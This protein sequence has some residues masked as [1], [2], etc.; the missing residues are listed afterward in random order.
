M[1]LSSYFLPTLREAPQDADN[2]SVK[3]MFRAG[4]IRKLASGIY[5]WLPLGLRVLRKVENIVREELDAIGGQ[6]VWLPVIQP[7]ELWM[8]TGRWQIYGKELLRIKDRKD[9]Q[10][11][12]AP[13]AEEVITNMVRRDVNSY[14]Q[15][16]IMLYQ[17]GLK[18]RDE[19][20]PRF[21]VM[22]AREFLM[23]D[24]YSFHASDEDC[25]KWY[26]RVYG[27]YERIFRR[28]GLS[29]KSV[30][31]DSGPIGGSQSHEFMVIAGTGEAEIA[32]CPA[33]GYG[34]NTEK[35]AVAETP[36]RK[37]DPSIFQPLKDV[38]T[39]GL[40]TVEDV[41]RFLKMNKKQFIKTLFFLAAGEP[42]MALVRGDH[43][44][45]ENKLRR[46]LGVDELEKAPPN[47][48]EAI[49]GCPA[50]FAGPVDIKNKYIPGKD[51]RPLK[52]IIADYALKGVFNGVSGA[53][54]ND[55][56]VTGINIGR[57]YNPDSFADLRVAAEGDLCPNC[58]KPFEF[59]R[60]IEVGQTFKLGTRYSKSLKCE[61][62]DERQ[63]SAPMVMGCYGIGVTRT[64]AAAIE[65]SHDEWGIIWPPAIAPFEFSLVTIETEDKESMARSQK[66][67]EQIHAAGFSALWDERNERPGVK[68]KDADLIG[69]PY[70]IVVSAKTLKDGECEFKKRAEKTATR[71]KLSELPSRLAEL[72][73][74][75]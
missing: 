69:L 7:R 19:I 40:Y 56:H 44:L 75:A 71:W 27:A 18:F 65:Q 62:L 26:G 34:A 38:P 51:T 66:V 74:S 29:F 2:I 6:E 4:M 35:A 73:S 30:E 25:E 5:E 68:F 14:R 22:R 17:F 42:V 39:P 52:T 47:I 33:C 32:F 57:D 41:A 60:G 61:F 13:T 31:A 36:V 43:E 10:F 54:K 45:N 21:G 16:P 46:A 24:A 49:A 63:K 64:V 70:R 72:K 1:K 8:E 9:S 28:C 20:R 37:A 11:C 12:F 55:T 15:L 50:G 53:C 48:Y 3:L 59:K 67:Y 23:K 58:R